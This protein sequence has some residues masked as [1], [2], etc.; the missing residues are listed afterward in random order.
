MSTEAV[1]LIIAFIVVPL[2]QQLRQGARK[3]QEVPP[4]APPP[5]GRQPQLPASTSPAAATSEPR[6][7]QLRRKSLQER[8]T[9]A[10]KPPEDAAVVPARV[11]EPGQRVPRRQFIL[12]ELRTPAGFRRAVVLRTILESGRASTPYE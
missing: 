9:P 4:V 1:L 2:I 10:E 11:S 12:E 7:P 5:K 6:Q 3:Q 8:M